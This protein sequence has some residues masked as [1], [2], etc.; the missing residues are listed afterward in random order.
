MANL[1]RYISTPSP[2]SKQ[3][4]PLTYDLEDI[5]KNFFTELASDENMANAAIKGS[6]P[7]QFD[8]AIKARQAHI[9]LICSSF[10]YYLHRFYIYALYNMYTERW[11]RTE[12]FKN[13]VL[14]SILPKLNGLSE[15]EAKR[16]F[17]NYMQSKYNSQSFLSFKMIET[18]LNTTDIPYADVLKMAFPNS[19]AGSPKNSCPILS[20]GE[21]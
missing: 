20:D 3:R 2:A 1:S 10:D 19:N 6:Q 21:T 9:I 16:E 15:D 8:V 13:T 14:P 4:E 5:K 12:S 7:G 18:V 11:T 17:F